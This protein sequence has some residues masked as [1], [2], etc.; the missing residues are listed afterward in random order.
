LRAPLKLA[1][2]ARV[3]LDCAILFLLT[4]VL[5]KPLFKAK[6]LEK[7]DSIESTF[8]SDARFLSEHWPHPQWQPLWYTGT[9]FDYI[10]PPMLRYGTAVLSK[11]IGYWPVKAYHVYTAFFYCVGIAGVYLLILAGSKSR[12][13]AWTGAAATALMSPSL[14]LLKSFRDDSWQL[15]PVRLGV[16]VKYGEGPHMTALALLPIALACSWLA[17]EKRRPWAVALAG[18]SAALVVSNNFYGATALAI[19]YPILLW[20][21]WITGRDRRIARIAIAIPAIAYGLT[22]FWLVPSY[23]RVTTEN[24]RYVSRQGTAWSLWI[25]LAIAIAFALGSAKLARGKPA[26]TWPVFV[27]GSLV[28]LTIDVLGN[29][30]FNFRIYGEP[31]R[32]VPELDLAIIMA[33]VTGLAWL[34]ARRDRAPR[35]AAALILIAAFAT[36]TGYIGHAWQ[37][38][39]P[40]RDYQSRVEYKISDWLHRNLPDAR[41]YTNGSVRFWFDTWHDLPQVG[42]GSDQGL[43]NGLIENVQWQINLDSNPETSVLWL[44][45]M[46][47]DAVYV[48]DQRSQEA[49]KDIR[50]PQ[51]FAGILPVLY[52]NGEGDV[53]YRV[54]RR[55]SARARIVDTER[56]HAL[57]NPQNN[58]DLSRLRA[59]ADVVECGPNAPVTVT[60]QGTDAMRIEATLARGQSVVVQ[61]SY[62]PAWHA[63]SGS[64]EL[65]VSR[66]AMGMMVVDAPPGTNSVF[67]KFVTPLENQLG[68]ILTALT[69]LVLVGIFLIEL[70]TRHKSEALT[71]SMESPW[72]SGSQ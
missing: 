69:V 71:G 2:R 67:L 53:L 8:I 35:I 40:A 54:P 15:A 21:F 43:L 25:G 10:Y 26:L 27:S 46:G 42:G 1:P 47:A 24:M 20:S 45:A 65:T 59:Y 5:I 12:W 49:Y 50:Y 34:T 33:A 64:R 63:W 66:D 16:L 44:Q 19:F 72:K 18:I 36:T 4:A 48:S 30:Y 61:E 28:F 29:Y 62:D 70:R 38:F 9:R 51:K 3:L 22:A 55:W 60:R 58:E 52:D 17:L 68:R 31:M 23:I 6:Y 39:P 37:M 11:T 32:L 14:L 7:W 41:A 57:E 13:M 56:L